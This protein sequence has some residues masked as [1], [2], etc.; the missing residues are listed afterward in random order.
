MTATPAAMPRII[1]VDDDFL[2]LTYLEEIAQQIGCQV[3]GTAGTPEE[4]IML[5]QN[6]RPDIALLDVRLGSGADGIT[7]GE[8]IR[9]H[10][11]TEVVFITGSTEPATVA[12]MRALAPRAILAKPIL[13]EQLARILLPPPPQ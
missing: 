10:L 3:V 8:Y 7:A 2:I 13:P 12:R 5:C 9:A 6:T 4:A 11:T 1:I